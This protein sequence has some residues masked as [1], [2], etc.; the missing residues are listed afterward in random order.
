MK[1][2][3]VEVYLDKPSK[4]IYFGTTSPRSTLGITYV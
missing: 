4:E 2:L 1:I 3:K